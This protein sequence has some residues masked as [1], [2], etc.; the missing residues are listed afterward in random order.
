MQ[1]NYY[2]MFVLSYSAKAL[3]DLCS[4]IAKSI[5]RVLSPLK[6]LTYIYIILNHKTRKLKVYLLQFKLNFLLK[7]RKSLLK[8]RQFQGIIIDKRQSF[9][10]LIGLVNKLILR[11]IKGSS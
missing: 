8:S 2:K 3:V 1:A 9:N 11:E 4:P 5:S 7:G 10:I 6:H